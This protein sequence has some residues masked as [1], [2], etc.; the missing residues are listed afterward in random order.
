[1]A[2]TREK[3]RPLHCITERY[4][5]IFV[6]LILQQVSNPY[7]IFINFIDLMFQDTTVTA[8][9]RS[10]PYGNAITSAQLQSTRSM[11]GPQ[12]KVLIKTS[13]INEISMHVILDLLK[14]AGTIH[15]F[16]MHA[17]SPHCPIVSRFNKT[18]REQ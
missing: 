5:F 2:A 12:S 17:E 11:T 10:V 1:M 8:M 7:N 18:P 4:V 13:E 6:I 9:L 3:G 14:P 16:R 15:E